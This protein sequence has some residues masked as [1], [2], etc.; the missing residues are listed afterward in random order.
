DEN[1]RSGNDSAAE[2]EIQLA[3]SRLPPPVLGRG[4]VPN[5][6]DFR[7]RSAL[8]Q[9]LVSGRAPR[10]SAWRLRRRGDFFD[11]G[12]PVTADFALAGPLR[13]VGPAARAAVNGFCLRAH[14]GG[15][16]ALKPSKSVNDLLKN[17]FTKPVGP[18]RCLP[19]MI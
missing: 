14:S 9:S 7:D 16:R 11:E 18:L 19:M 3:H 10:R 4:D 2:H 17:M 6:G 1:H 12:I 8:R 13:M 5:G 15:L